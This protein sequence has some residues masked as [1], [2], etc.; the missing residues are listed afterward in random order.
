M[1][2][3]C[4]ILYI[5]VTQYNFFLAICHPNFTFGTSGHYGSIFI[6]NVLCNKQRKMMEKIRHLDDPLWSLTPLNNNQ[7]G[8]HIYL[9][10]STSSS[11]CCYKHFFW[12]S[13][14][15]IKTLPAVTSPSNL[16]PNMY[17]KKDKWKD[18]FS[19]NGSNKNTY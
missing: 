15:L 8:E 13:L 11:P 6:V 16:K 1:Q 19:V 10:A 5:Y 12:W 18:Q 4:I 7:R 9:A 17:V 14:M 3:F 2:F